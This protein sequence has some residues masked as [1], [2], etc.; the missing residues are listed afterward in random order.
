VVS[1]Q[2]VVL[3]RGLEEGPTKVQSQR[4]G[5]PAQGVTKS[6][7]VE[8]HPVGDILLDTGC[9]TTLVQRELVPEERLLDGEV[10]VRCAHGDTTTYPL[11]E[12]VVEVQG[13]RFEGMA[14]VSKT[15]PVSVLLGTDFPGMMDGAADHQGD[16]LV[17]TRA[18]ARK[19]GS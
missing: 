17:V 15:L 13:V 9:S 7:T 19:D 4:Q 14:G 12:V 1:K 11:A 16:A 18:Q 10:T 5:K 2:C 6:G 3:P 8:G